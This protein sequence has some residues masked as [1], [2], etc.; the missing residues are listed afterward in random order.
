M[1]TIA[2]LHQRFLECSGACTDTRSIAPQS[3]FFALKGPH[4]NANAFAAEALA[5]GSR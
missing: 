5:P 2:A 1:I 4:F 3:L